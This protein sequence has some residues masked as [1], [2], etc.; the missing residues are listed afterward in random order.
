[1]HS[2]PGT[3][4]KGEARELTTVLHPAFSSYSG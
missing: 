1:M 4:V 2:P 3:A